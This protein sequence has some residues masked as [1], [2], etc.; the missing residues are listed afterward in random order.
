MGRLQGGAAGGHA[1]IVVP[2]IGSHSWKGYMTIE[3]MR[4]CST[5]PSQHQSAPARSCHGLQM[6]RVPACV[7]HGCSFYSAGKGFPKCLLRKMHFLSN[8]RRYAHAP[9]VPT[10][11]SLARPAPTHR[12]SKFASLFRS[13]LRPNPPIQ[14][15]A[16][17]N[18]GRPR[19]ARDFLVFLFFHPF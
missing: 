19:N 6:N 4:H 16:H 1:A 12:S 10:P 7:R 11:V 2:G 13:Q 8:L 15:A 17:F 18:Q 9:R 14:Y 3:F 5:T